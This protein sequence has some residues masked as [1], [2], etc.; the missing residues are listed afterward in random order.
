M[1]EWREP[2]MVVRVD[3]PT[4][5]GIKGGDALALGLVRLARIWLEIAHSQC[6]RAAKQVKKR[7]VSNSPL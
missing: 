1:S 2:L 4:P 6:L 7:G 5:G 3:W